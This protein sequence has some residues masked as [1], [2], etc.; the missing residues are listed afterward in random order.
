MHRNTWTSVFFKMSIVIFMLFCLHKNQLIVTLTDEFDVTYLTSFKSLNFQDIINEPLHLAN[1]SDSRTMLV[2]QV[3]QEKNKAE[4][5][6]EDIDQAEDIKKSIYIYNTHQY[7]QYVGG[8]VMQGARYLADELEKRGYEVIVEENDFEAFKRANG[9]DLTETYPTSK[10]FLERQLKSHGPFDLIIDFHRD[11]I[12]K[13]VSTFEDGTTSY[14][15]MMMVISLTTDYH[16]EVEA[17]STAIHHE[18]DQI[19]T[20]LMRSDFKRDYA[21]YNQQ[22]AHSMVLIEIGGMENTYDEV[23]N[24]LNVLAAA[25]DHALEEEKIE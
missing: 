18:V 8:N 19:L 6:K 7:E 12:S 1:T 13:E 4:V 23:Q 24:S 9:M 25:I 3:F 17:N 10:I 15:K 5:S 14:A 21:Y 16:E 11:S 20:G 2:Q 22:C